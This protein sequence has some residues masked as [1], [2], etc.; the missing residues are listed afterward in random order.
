MSDFVTSTMDSMG[1]P[2]IALLMLLENIVPPIPSEIVMPAAGASA[3]NGTYS[4]TGVVIA[5]TAGSVLGA[6]PWYGAARYVG[7]D[8]LVGW[9]KR[10]GHWLGT[11]EKEIRRADAWFDRN[12]QWA[13]LG[14]RMVPGLRTLISVPAGFAEMPLVPFLI[15]TT[16]GTT[17]W[18]LLLALA[19]Y[20]LQGQK[21]VIA[22]TVQWVAL[23]VFGVLFLWFL[24][25]I[26]RRQREKSRSPG[27]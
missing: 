8:R 20:W 17:G 4:L 7:T 18:S 1:Y 14:C 6:L 12:G 5:G 25:R 15:W 13:V 24:V 16:I 26:V 2:G 3:R 11:D 22:Q 9:V 23:A 27:A 21:P 10:H 19:G